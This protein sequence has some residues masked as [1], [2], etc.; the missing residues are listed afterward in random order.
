RPQG[1]PHVAGDV[2]QAGLRLRGRAAR[3]VPR[4]RPLSRHGAHGGAA[5]G[6]GGR[7]LTTADETDPR[8]F[9]ADSTIAGAG[10]GLFARI[11]LAAGES[12]RV[13]GVLIASGS[14]ADDCTRFADA[15]KFRV[16]DYLLIPTGYAAL[17]N[18]SKARANLEKVVTG[19]EVFL[20]T[21][22]PVAAGEELFFCYSEYAQER[23]GLS[24]GRE[25]HRTTDY[26]D[27]TDKK[28]IQRS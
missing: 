20:R 16:G 11:D 12:L 4:R 18:H 8:F 28:R 23:F 1:Q 7:V 22:R 10:R 25:E 3:R 27:N 2:P 15:Y 9:V 19:H 14:V 5:A 24:D 13:V 21:T 17:V 26:T 6:V